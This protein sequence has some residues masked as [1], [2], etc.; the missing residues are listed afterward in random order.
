MKTSCLNLAL[1]CLALLT[2]GAQEGCK[3]P[4]KD[5]KAAPTKGGSLAA[6]IKQAGT[7]AQNALAAQEQRSAEAAAQVLAALLVNALQPAGQQTVFI[8]KELRLATNNLPAPDAKAMLEAEARK[9]ATLSTNLSEMTRLYGEAQGKSE[10]LLNQFVDATNK[11]NQAQAALVAAEKAHMAD[12]ERSRAENQAKLDAAL[13]EAAEAKEKAYQERQN[14]LFYILCG[15]GGLCLVAGI[16]L[17]FISNGTQ[18]LRSAVLG[19]CA[20]FCFGLAKI[21]SHPWFNT[22]F[23]VCC[24]LAAVGFGF[25]LWSERREAL[26]QRALQK[27]AALLERVDMDKV[28]V[29]DDDGR[30]SN[31]RVELSRKMDTAEKAEVRKVR[32]ALR[33]KAAKTESLA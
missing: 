11:L 27:T 30:P 17:A 1:L 12:L 14:L 10:R 13:R 3:T 24:A 23:L 6:P 7:N 33:L 21:V 5:T 16:A 26:R 9:S 4:P 8:D 19:G 25:Y 28:P 32:T 15:I 20:L 2:M 31:L 22:A 29:E 18:A